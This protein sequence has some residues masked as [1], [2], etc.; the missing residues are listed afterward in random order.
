MRFCR[1]HSRKPIE[2]ARL[3]LTGNVD[4]G[5]QVVTNQDLASVLRDAIPPNN[6]VQFQVRTSQ[7][8]PEDPSPIR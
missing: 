6:K 2:H 7:L 8:R 3:T 1:A 5:T 4:S